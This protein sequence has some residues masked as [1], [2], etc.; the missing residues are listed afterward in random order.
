MKKVRRFMVRIFLALSMMLISFELLSQ[1]SIPDSYE[2]LIRERHVIQPKDSGLF[3]DEVGLYMGNLEFVQT[4]IDVPGNNSLPVSLSRRFVVSSSNGEARVFGD[5]DL[6]IPHVHGMFTERSG[7]S[8]TRCSNMWPPGGESGS[9]G[10]FFPA[11]LFWN[12]NYVYLPGSGDQELLRTGQGAGP[13]DG[14]S[15]PLTTRDRSVFRCIAL[16]AGGT[17]EGFLM[18]RPDGTQYRFDYMVSRPAVSIMDAIDKPIRVRDTWILPTL[19]TDRFGNTV[20]YTWSNWQLVSIVASDG[21]R[22]DVTGFPITSATDGAR[23]WNYQY[24]TSGPVR[25]RLDRL[26]LPDGSAWQFNIADLYFNNS[27]SA[28]ASADCDNTS[29]SLLG[30]RRTG[31][32]THPTGAVGE[33]SVTGL[34]HGRSWVPSNCKSYG[35]AQPAPMGYPDQPRVIPGWSIIQKKIAG[36]GIPSQ[37]YS[38]NYAYGPT[39]HC[40]AQKVYGWE[41][42]VCSAASPTT[43]TVSVTGPDSSTVRYTFGNRYKINEGQLLR[44]DEG[45]NGSN[46]IRATINT[47]ASPDSGPYPRSIG[48]SMMPRGD[49]EMGSRYMPLQSKVVTEQ[50]TTFRWQVASD[51]AGVPYCFDAYARPTK[52]TKSSSP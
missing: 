49:G 44:I 43:K 6:N 29:S 18:I 46:S 45:W 30:G 10:E 24:T 8:N 23:R 52:V 13:T 41:T 33:F 2:K 48:G 39:N 34:E 25:P 4:D 36:P 47:Y 15:Y 20:T 50:G 3:G 38:W 31:T 11:D 16:S 19:V 26:V 21:R 5:W 32:M 40:W 12:G 17:G 27:P 37:G 28:K 7:W 51:C 35:Y 1:T 9:G 22:I 42:A 14:N